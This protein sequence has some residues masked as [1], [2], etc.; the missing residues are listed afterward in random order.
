MKLGVVG[1]PIAHS[2]SPRLHSAAYGVLG[3]RWAYSAIEV[4]KGS[5][6][7]TVRQLDATWRGLSVTA[8][9][10]DEAHELAAQLDDD[11]RL[12]GAVNTL[13]VKSRRGFN[14]DVDGIVGAFA[15]RRVRNIRRASVIGGG[16]TAA[17]A[18][19]ALHRMGAAAIDVRLRSPER[20]ASL[21][22]IADALGVELQVAH[23]DEPVH[24]A[25]AIVSTLPAS[26]AVI[27]AI[28][29]GGTILDAD[30]AKGASRYEFDHE[31]RV[32]SGLEML[33]HQ[34]LTQV[35]IF[36]GGD[37]ARALPNEARVIEAMRAS[38]GLS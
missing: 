16:A 24:D 38:V 6:A 32:I 37:P 15:T 25:Q 36:V 10:K 3:L 35:R 21:Q 27:P 23:L 2:K 14:T 26:A 30:Y 5:L 31:G 22:P 4:P 20:A 29:G 34:A 11:A 17:S 19:V 7:D 9:L 12:T 1:S 18:V 8:P 33:A 13:L 28:E